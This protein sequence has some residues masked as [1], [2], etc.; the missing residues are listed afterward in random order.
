MKA[1]EHE[2]IKRIAQ[3]ARLDLDPAETNDL[4]TQLTDILRYMEQL[5]SV[6]TQGV[7][8]LSHVHEIVNQLRADEVQS[9]LD[10]ET[11]LRNAPDADGT[12][13]KV[14]RVIKD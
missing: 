7:E 12:Y 9:S 8:P 13:F 1:V 10:R 5:N 14:P 3:L 4:A 11:A 6:D 2:E